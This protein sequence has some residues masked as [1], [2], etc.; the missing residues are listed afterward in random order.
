MRRFFAGGSVHGGLLRIPRRG[1]TSEARA[2]ETPDG[3]H[4]QR[5]GSEPKETFGVGGAPG[6]PEAGFAVFALVAPEAGSAGFAL[7]AAEAGFA[8]F[9]IV[10]PEAGFAPDAP[11]AVFAGAG[12]TCAFGISDM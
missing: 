9:A 5:P 6:A 4:G 10:G 12:G 1:G 2:G 11:E 3:A 7:V 8:G